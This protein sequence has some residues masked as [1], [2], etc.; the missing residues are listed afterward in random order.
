MRLLHIKIKYKKTTVFILIVLILIIIMSILVIRLEQPQSVQAVFGK[1]ITSKS[2]FNIDLTPTL[3]KDSFVAFNYPKGLS[4]KPSNPLAAT[5]V[6]IIDFGAQDILSWTLAIDVTNT[7]SKP[8]N[9]DS[10]YRIRTDQQSIYKQSSLYIGNQNVTVMTDTTAS[11][12]S[13]VAFLQHGNLRATVALIGDDAD[14]SSPLQTSW[15]MILSSWQW[16]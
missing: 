7:G 1:S 14:G 10:S 15:N 11:G 16:Q 2:G 6:D 13:R 5:D 3:Y 12:F 8:L 9:D 4:K